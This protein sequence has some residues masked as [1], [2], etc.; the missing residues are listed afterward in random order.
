MACGTPVIGANTSSLPEVI[1]LE[2]ALFD[3]LDVQAMSTKIAEVLSSSE[4][5]QKMRAHG[6]EQAKRFSWDYTAQRA[7]TA[8]EEVYTSSVRSLALVDLNRLQQAKPK[9]A[10]VS[11]LPPEHTVIADYSAELLPA[12]ALYY[13]IYVIVE[14]EQISNPWIQANC[15]QHDAAWLYAHAHEMDRVLYQVGNSPFQAYM[16][17][18][19]QVIPGTVVLHDFYLSGLMGWLEEV[20]GV[21]ARWTHALYLSHGYL[22]VQSGASADSKPL[23][24]WSRPITIS[25]SSTVRRRSAC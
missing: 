4:L 15:K 3:P 8:W 10:F 5:R 13:D 25:C 20:A 24:V 9:L 19:I 23:C 7:L 14:Q 16:L 17:P 2:E 18:L 12:L 22:A 1:N 11:P 21:E 6:F